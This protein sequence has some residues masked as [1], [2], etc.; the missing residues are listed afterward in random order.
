MWAQGTGALLCG[1]GQGSLSSCWRSEY[2]RDAQG[3]GL[4][5]GEKGR[6]SGEGGQ[7]M[8]PAGGP[9]TGSSPSLGRSILLGS[10]LDCG[11]CLRGQVGEWSVLRKITVNTM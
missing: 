11:A 8:G 1:R 5:P 2:G 6:G 3:Q 4:S 10:G 7:F 9:H